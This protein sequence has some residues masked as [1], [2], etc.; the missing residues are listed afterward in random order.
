VDGSWHL[1]E[2]RVDAA[3]KRR[4]TIVTVRPRNSC[5]QE[6]TAMTDNK[7]TVGINVAGTRHSVTVMAEDAL[8]AALKVKLEQPAAAINFV[9]RCNKRGDLR[10]PHDAVSAQPR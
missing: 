10:H 2:H 8:V 1:C 4:H 7:F 5:H 9:R 3:A 6:D